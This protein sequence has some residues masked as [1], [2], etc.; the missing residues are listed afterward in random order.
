[1]K[2]A[3]HSDLHTEYSLC[4]LENLAAADVLILAGDIGDTSSLPHFFSRLRK[5]AP[6]LAVLYILGNHDRWGMDW[7]QGIAKHRA[8]AQE[9]DIQ[10]LENQALVIDEVLFCGTTLWTNFALAQEQE[11]SIA[12]AAQNIPDFRYIYRQGK[13]FTIQDMLHEHQQALQFLHSALTE[14]STVRKKVVISHFVPARELVAEKYQRSSAEF[15]KSAYWTSDLPEIYRLADMWIYG[16]S[17]DNIELTIGQTRF[18]SNQRGYHRIFNAYHAN[19]HYRP[20]YLIE[21]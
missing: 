5:Q 2:I 7:A 21:L 18:V 12:W 6:Q 9:Y 3:V 4:E 20:D 14:T 13:P 19:S 10:L 17:H 1:M 15:I 16:H 11:A 8:I